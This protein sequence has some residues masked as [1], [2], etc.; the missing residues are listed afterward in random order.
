MLLQDFAEFKRNEIPQGNRVAL[1]QNTLVFASGP[2]LNQLHFRSLGEPVS[3]DLKDWDVLDADGHVRDVRIAASLVTGDVLGCCVTNS[4]PTVLFRVQEGAKQAQLVDVVKNGAHRVKA[5]NVNRFDDE[6]VV[7]VDELG[8]VYPWNLSY[9]ATDTRYHL[10][11]DD[12]CIEFSKAC[13]WKHPRVV[14]CALSRGVF[15]VDFRSQKVSSCKLPVDNFCGFACRQANGEFQFSVVNPKRVFLFDSRYSVAPIQEWEHPSRTFPVSELDFVQIDGS[16]YLYGFNASSSMTWMFPYE[17]NSVQSAMS[18][19]PFPLIRLD[20]VGHCNVPIV[21]S[22]LIPGQDSQLNAI[23]LS[24]NGNLL[25]HHLVLES[26]ACNSVR[27]RY[28]FLENGWIRPEGRLRR[29]SK[30]AKIDKVQQLCIPKRNLGSKTFFPSDNEE[31]LLNQFL[32]FPRT[33]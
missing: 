4:G 13:F 3:V 2:I 6:S 33:L 1:S 5:A 14:Y 28:A 9:R 10:Q 11:Q 8:I 24:Y 26:A 12:Q 18:R 22:Q 29:R 30:I 20:S 23:S 15:S 19:R 31:P 21:G 17:N 32:I 27:P 16:E 25:Q 7:L